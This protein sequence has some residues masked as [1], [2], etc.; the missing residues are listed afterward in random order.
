MRIAGI[1]NRDSM[2]ESLENR[3]LLSAGQLD[4]TFSGDGRLVANFTDRPTINGGAVQSDGKIIIVGQTHVEDENAAHD[5][6]VARYTSG[7]SLDT[8]FSGDGIAKVDFGG[9]DGAFDVAID[10][11][12]RIVVAGVGNGKIGVAR[13]LSNGSLDTSF[14]GD[15]KQTVDFGSGTESS[16]HLVIQ[17]DGKIVVSGTGFALAR[18]TT[19]GNLDSTFDGDGKVVVSGKGLQELRDLALAPDGKIVAGGGGD[20]NAAEDAAIARFNT[21]GSL[22]SSFTPSDNLPVSTGGPGYAIFEFETGP[23]ESFDDN[24]IEGVAVQSDG[25]VV[26]TGFTNEFFLTTWRIDSTGNGDVHDIAHD[27]KAD[28]AI[29]RSVTVQSD[30][31][32][33]VGGVAVES[34]SS[35]PQNFLLI[36]YNANGTRDTTFGV[37][38]VVETELNTYGPNNLGGGSDNLTAL[39]V[40]GGKYVAVGN[41]TGT[42]EQTP[43]AIARYD[44]GNTQYVSPVTALPDGTYQ[45]V[46]TN[47]DDVIHIYEY[48]SFPTYYAA[49]VNGAIFSFIN[50]AFKINTFDGDDLV[51]Q[52][53]GVENH[54]TIDGGAG[55][56]TLGGNEGLATIYGGDGNDYIGAVTEAAFSGTYRLHGGIGQDLLQGGDNGGDFLSGDGGNDKVNGGGGNDRLEG[57]AGNDAIYGDGGPFISNGTDALFGGSGDDV[58]DGGF[59]NDYMEGGD[60]NDTV[61]YESRTNPVTVGLGTSA[62]DGEAGEGDNARDDIENI[63]GGAGNDDLRGS[64]S[65]NK[66][67]GLGGN[68]LIY[69]HGGNDYAEGGSG[70]DTIYGEG[71]NDSLYGNAGADRL[72]GGSDND[73]LEGGSGADQFFG[74]SGNDTFFAKDGEKDLLNGGSGTDSAQRDNSAS[75]KDDVLSIESFIA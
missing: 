45:I 70:N 25:K 21:N 66:I 31:K 18:L 32:I 20:F 68:D 41:T 17:S 56:D 5:F 65:V 64:A 14:S 57:N 59:G 42:S 35:D 62:D 6:F 54:C 1:A 2:I 44:G 47:G 38:G 49:D 7:G 67:Y 11:S 27:L 24:R 74:Q 3:R 19:G 22:D 43:V 34:P 30:G 61:T 63:I 60:G 26:M 69:L 53:F 10:S 48:N 9:N 37:N 36:R 72:D 71:G 55:N 52:N 13:L 75:V 58:L 33:V 8:S 51:T 39:I 46:G 4:P 73:R 16:S 28:S 23:N 15:G 40:S 50:N 12:G 29:G